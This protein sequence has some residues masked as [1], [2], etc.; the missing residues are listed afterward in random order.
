[1]VKEAERNF[2]CNDI[3]YSQIFMNANKKPKKNNIHL[4]I[5]FPLFQNV[6]WF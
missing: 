1:M 2:W 3:I 4:S 6:K 5:F